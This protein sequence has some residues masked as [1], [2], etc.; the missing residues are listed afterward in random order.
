MLFP[1]GITGNSVDW[2]VF[3]SFTGQKSNTRIDQDFDLVPRLRSARTS[4]SLSSKPSFGRLKLKAWLGQ[5]GNVWN[6]KKGQKTSESRHF[7]NGTSALQSASQESQKP[8]KASQDPKQII[9]STFIAVGLGRSAPGERKKE[10]DWFEREMWIAKNGH[11]ANP[12][13]PGT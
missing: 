13:E 12:L 8:H 2:G 9:S 6:P 3:L 5:C 7:E 1:A 10:G 4:S 11:S